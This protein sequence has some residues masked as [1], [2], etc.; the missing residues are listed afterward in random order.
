MR[1]EL[2]ERRSLDSLFEGPIEG[3]VVPFMGVLNLKIPLRNPTKV[4]FPHLKGF[5]YPA[6]Q[7]IKLVRPG[8]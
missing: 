7:S 4:V 2:R 8:Y 5:P 3:N 6:T 1:L